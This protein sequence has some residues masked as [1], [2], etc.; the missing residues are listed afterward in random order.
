MHKRL[1]DMG[2]HLSKLGKSLGTATLAYNSAVGTM[3]SR[4]LVSA[5]RFKEM[6]SAAAS[7][8]IDD[9][10]QISTSIRQLQAPE[11]TVSDETGDGHAA[12]EEDVKVAEIE[13]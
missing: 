12:A 9:L 4:V 8:D 10:P 7:V 6:G 2:K 3:E 5:R 1:A 11:L 13:K